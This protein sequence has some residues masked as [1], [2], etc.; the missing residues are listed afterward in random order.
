MTAQELA[1]NMPDPTDRVA[2]TA[3]E[4]AENR[5][6]SCWSV[7]ERAWK[8]VLP[9]L[10]DDVIALLATPVVV[11]AE[12]YNAPAVDEGPDGE[13][14]PLASSAVFAVASG[15]GERMPRFLAPAPPRRS[16]TRHNART[17]ART[18]IG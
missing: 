18:R 14:A 5:S 1:T 16:S 2:V 7:Q 6:T 3:A 4:V 10:P 17:R 12:A 9:D 13:P 8:Q 11:T 15:Y